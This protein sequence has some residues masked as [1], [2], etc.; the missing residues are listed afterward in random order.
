MN[1]GA[2]VLALIT[3]LAMLV[4]AVGCNK[5][6]AR[7]QLNKGVQSF[8]NNKFEQSIEHFKNAVSLDPKLGT[9]RLYLATAYAQMVI[10][11]AQ[12]P[13]NTRFAEQAIAEYQKVI[14]TNPPL[15][16]QVNSLKGI[17]GLYRGMEKYVEAR[18]VYRKIAT[19]DPNDAETYYS[20]AW[21]DWNE[22]YGKGQ[23]LRADL[24]LQPADQIKDKK[25]CEAL[26]TANA[27][28]VK[29]GMQNLEK[30]LQIRP[31]YADAMAYMNLLY[32]QKADIECDDA[33]ARAADLKAA[34]EWVD[35]TLAAKKKE[36]EKNTNS[37]IVLDQGK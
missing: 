30:A 29:D 5:L 18:D 6:K 22:A 17:A 23:K 32:R 31:E 14:E 1:R 15:E 11:G 27:E 12:T 7:D 8:K 10:P 28:K 36:A 3:A 37:G 34:D 20:I 33:A 4:G 21:V 16:Q 26:R 25:A 35:K 13:E 9:A 2:R 19:L 24:K